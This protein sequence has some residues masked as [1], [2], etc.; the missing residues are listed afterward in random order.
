MS[1]SLGSVMVGALVVAAV[2]VAPTRAPLGRETPGGPVTP[3]APGV[4]GGCETASDGERRARLRGWLTG[5]RPSARRAAVSVTELTEALV[6]LALA[7]RS[8]LPTCDVLEA[9]AARSSE[10]VARDLRQ[11]SAA[12]RWGAS[13]TEAWAAVDDRWAPAARA[14]TLASRAGIAPGPLLLRAADDLGGAELERLEISAAKVAVRLV[15][16]LGLVL[17]PA[18]VLTT[19]LPIVAALAR[20]VLSSA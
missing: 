6:L 11:V 2:L 5:S 9:V 20:Q 4:S 3:G 16:P 18:F 10:A 15:L 8:G 14:V 12:L 17:L 1:A 19:V 7:Y 13:E